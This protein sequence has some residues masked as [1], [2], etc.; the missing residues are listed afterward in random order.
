MPTR[1]LAVEPHSM[2]LGFDVRTELLDSRLITPRIT[3]ED[4]Q[5]SFNDL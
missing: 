1:D 5:R 3:D 2:P 4:A